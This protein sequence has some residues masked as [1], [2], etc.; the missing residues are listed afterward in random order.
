LPAKQLGGVEDVLAEIM[1]SYSDRFAFSD[2]ERDVIDQRVAEEQP[3]FSRPMI[4]PSYSV[5]P[6]LHDICVGHCAFSTL[7]NDINET[8]EGE[9]FVCALPSP[10]PVS[11]TFSQTVEA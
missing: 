7:Q 8:G 11:F 1:E 4:S 3:A 9:L 10:P 2:A 5:N 6:S